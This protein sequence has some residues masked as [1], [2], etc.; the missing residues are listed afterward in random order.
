MEG[1]G[2]MATP[3]LASNMGDKRRRMQLKF[4]TSV[5]CVDFVYRQELPTIRFLLNV[6]AGGQFRAV[7]PVTF[8]LVQ[9]P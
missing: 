5:T 9:A 2:Q 4:L 8:T 7:Q 6:T 3:P 1:T